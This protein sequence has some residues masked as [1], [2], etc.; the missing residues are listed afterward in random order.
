MNAQKGDEFRKV[1]INICC[2]FVPSGS[3]AAVSN[4]LIIVIIYATA[5]MEFIISWPAKYRDIAPEGVDDAAIISLIQ[6]SA[7]NNAAI[8]A[9]IENMWHGK[10]PFRLYD[11]NRSLD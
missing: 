8:S 9:A 6:R 3:S 11:D 5:L 1:P 7:G 4:N 10:L 2:F